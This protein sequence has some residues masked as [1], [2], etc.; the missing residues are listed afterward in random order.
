MTKF[1]S[2]DDILE[3]AMHQEQRAA[4]F[5]GRMIDKAD[6]D[7]IKI[8]LRELEKEE[9]RHKAKLAGVRKGGK[10]DSSSAPVQDL[11]ISDYLVADEPEGEI[12]YQGALILAAKKEQVAWK[13]YVDLAERTED[14]EAKSVFRAL[15]KEEA[16]H[17]LLLET[18]YDDRVLG[19]N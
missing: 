14:P 13:L 11:K 7:S 8:T 15:A 17:K 4:D 9:L 10:L 18:E 5:Y 12:D 3:F 19:Q 2:I 16:K 1:Q 6:T